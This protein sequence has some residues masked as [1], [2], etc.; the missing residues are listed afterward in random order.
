VTGLF[1]QDIW[2]VTFGSFMPA[3]LFTTLS[4][5]AHLKVGTFIAFSFG[6][7]FFLMI[8]FLILNTVYQTKR[9]NSFGEYFT[10]AI[11]LLICF[12]WFNLGL[13]KQYTGLILINFGIVESLI[14]CKMII[15]SVTK[16]TFAIHVDAPRVLPLRNHPF[17]HWNHF[18]D[19]PRFKTECR[20]PNYCLLGTLCCQ[21]GHDSEVLVVHHQ[22][23]HQVLGHQLFQH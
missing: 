8:V 1:G 13:Y 17:H 16:V 2:L 20:W 7:A 19:W 14:I 15:S 3:P 18:N 10:L 4:W 9:F 21:S 6:I 11:L 12:V 22:P 5:L 23:N